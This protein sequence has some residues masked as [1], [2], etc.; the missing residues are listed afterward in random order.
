MGYFDKSLIINTLYFLTVFW[1]C[2]FTKMALPLQ[3]NRITVTV[4]SHHR[5]GAI[6]MPLRCNRDAVTV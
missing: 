3:C 2:Q 6:A 5:Y 1:R 4:Q